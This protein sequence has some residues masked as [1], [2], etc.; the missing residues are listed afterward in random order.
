LNTKRKAKRFTPQKKA[1]PLQLAGKTISA[2]NAASIVAAK[3]LIASG[4]S[5]LDDVL[6]SAGL[7]GEEEVSASLDWKDSGLIGCGSWEDYMRRSFWH[8]KLEGVLNVFSYYFE[9][10][11]FYESK[12]ETDE[13]FGS[14]EELKESLMMF[15]QELQDSYEST[16]SASAMIQAASIDDAEL[17]TFTVPSLTLV[18]AGNSMNRLPIE[19]ML[20]QCDIVSEGI[21]AKGPGKRLMIP[22]SVAL[23]AVDQIQSLPL[24]ADPSLRKHC[25]NSIVGTMLSARIKDDNGFWISGNLFPWSQPEIVAAI[26]ASKHEMGFS[27]N[28]YTRGHDEEINAEMV[29]V[30]DELTLVGANILYADS[31]TFSGTKLVAAAIPS[32]PDRTPDRTITQSITEPALIA[33]STPPE[34]KVMEELLKQLTE[35]VKTQAATLN[36]MGETQTIVMKGLEV[37][38]A[39]RQATQ[40]TAAALAL[41]A[42]TKNKEDELVKKIASMLSVN[43]NGTGRSVQPARI[44]PSVLQSSAEHNPIQTQIALLQAELTGLKAT[45]SIA[46]DIMTRRIKLTDDIAALRS[47]LVAV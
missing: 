43:P 30:I 12:G 20:F 36:Q 14:S 32:I 28:A 4:L 39:D 40:E 7:V 47:Q 27:I 3:E 17:M 46:Q 2:K 11:L 34:D 22:R 33:A 26:R 42:E 21:P 15:L 9:G 1:S 31:A 29:H 38:L 10:A 13:Y 35:Q 6:E 23:K 8:Q 37:L 44:I 24:D 16:L 5:S 18:Q 45:G 25:N 41:E 19:G